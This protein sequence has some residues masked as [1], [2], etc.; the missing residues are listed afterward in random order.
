MDRSKIGALAHLVPTS[1]LS[2]QTSTA[3]TIGLFQTHAD[4]RAG[5][6]DEVLVSWEWA[7][8]CG[9]TGSLNLE[10]NP[11][12]CWGASPSSTVLCLMRDLRVP[13]APHLCG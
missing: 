13:S 4:F 2:S 3:R 8:H 7:Y 12:G 1:P 9:T 11:H 10:G 5:V 6:V